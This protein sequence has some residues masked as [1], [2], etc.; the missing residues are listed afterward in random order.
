VSLGS[1]RVGE[2]LFQAGPSTFYRGHNAILGSEVMLRRLTLDPARAQDARETFYREMRLSAAA[3]HP[4]VQRPLDVFEEEGHLWSVHEAHAL[5]PTERVVRERGPL[6]VGDAARVGAQVA[7]ALAHLHAMGHVHGRVSP[8]T[9]V[10]DERGNALLLNLVKAADL[11]A[12]IWPLRPAVLGL[13]PFSSPE[14]LGGGRPRPADDTYSLAATVFWWLTGHWPRGGATP[15]EALARAHAG[16]APESLAVACPEAPAALAQRIDAALSAEPH[17][18]RGSVSALGSLLAEIHQRHAAEAPTGFRSGAVLRP[19]G[20]E[21]GVHLLGRQGAGAFGVVFRARLGDSGPL[22]AVKVLKSEFRDDDQ[23]VERFL[24]EARSMQQVRHAN[25]VGIH[26][27]GD[28]DGIPYVVMEF[29]DGPDLAVVLRREGAVPA[30][31][32]I[33]LGRAMAEGLA[34]IH[35]EGI[36]HRDLKPH[37]VLLASGERPVIADFGIA[38]HEAA[39]RLTMTGQLAGT[40]L[41]M[42]PE[43]ALGDAATPAADLYSL[44]TILYELLAGEVPFPARDPISAITAIRERPV[45]PVPEDAP[46]PLR[47]LIRALLAKEPGARPPSAAAVASA[48]A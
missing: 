9:V 32:V 44:G 7:D 39:P 13:S 41:Y 16:V 1:Y 45:P 48:L 28:A 2:E 23:A 8:Q 10:L 42:A 22:V 43:V 33:R 18:P 11:A 34:A 20:C 47:S 15:E 5:L 17:A 46:A 40:P 31:R 30:P 37:N 21:H 27:V 6:P 36:V 38:R 35:R 4:H 24:R 26:G 25:V 3:R 12:G 14:E 19:R 29:V